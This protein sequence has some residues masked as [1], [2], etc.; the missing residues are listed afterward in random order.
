MEVGRRKVPLTAPTQVTPPSR[1]CC[2]KQV[3]FGRGIIGESSPEGQEVAGAGPGGVWVSLG[4]GHALRSRPTTG[5]CRCTT[6]V[7]CPPQGGL[8]RVGTDRPRGRLLECGGQQ[9]EAGGGGHC[10]TFAMGGCSCTTIPAICPSRGG[11]AGLGSGRLRG[12][13]RV[14]SRSGVGDG[15]LW[16]G[17]GLGGGRWIGNWRGR[18]EGGQ[19]AART[20]LSWGAQDG[21][22]GYHGG[23]RV[24]SGGPAGR[25]RLQ[26]SWSRPI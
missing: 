10:S 12:I 25:G 17:G 16:R 15:G 18:Q 11:V 23:R 9:V 22:Q 4:R 2:L 14:G 1:L 26:G 7:S 21:S 24:K 20:G 5:R 6:R 19:A 3:S 13:V 8:A